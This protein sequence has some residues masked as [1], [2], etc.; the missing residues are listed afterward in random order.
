MRARDAEVE[1]AARKLGSVADIEIDPALALSREVASPPVENGDDVV[2]CEAEWVEEERGVE[3]ALNDAGCRVF[4]DHAR[5]G[6]AVD[7]EAEIVLARAAD[8]V[9][10]IDVIIGQR[11]PDAGKRG[12]GNVEACS[13]SRRGLG[14]DVGC[15]AEEPDDI[16]GARRGRGI[17]NLQGGVEGDRLTDEFGEERRAEGGSVGGS[18][19]NPI[20][21]FPSHTELRILGTAELVIVL[22]PSSERQVK[23]AKARYRIVVAEYRNQQ[24]GVDRFDGARTR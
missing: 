22:D 24:F 16:G 4:G 15:I 3:I 8:S 10:I 19:R 14:L 17:G 7:E 20:D 23:L 12:R 5:K 13:P 1:R 21:G 9:P 11:C 2:R 6:F 18:Q